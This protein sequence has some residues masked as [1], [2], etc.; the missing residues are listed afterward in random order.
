MCVPG[1]LENLGSYL[2]LEVPASDEEPGMESQVDWIS[3]QATHWS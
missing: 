2:G 3:R 1:K